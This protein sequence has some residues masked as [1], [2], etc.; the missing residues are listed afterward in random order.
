MD[1][2]NSNYNATYIVATALHPVLAL[3]LNESQLQSARQEIIELMKNE[4]AQDLTSEPSGG[5]IS[6][7]SGHHGCDIGD[8][9]PHLKQKIEAAKQ[10]GIKAVSSVEEEANAYF[11]QLAAFTNIKCEMEF[12]VS[13]QM[14]FPVLASLAFDVLAIPASSAAIESVFSIA[15][16]ATSAR[17]HNLSV[18][19]EK[20]VMIKVNKHFIW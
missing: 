9:F 16:H 14:Q 20:E 17:R 2:R 3:S 8:L 11:K 15:G 5:G 1:P 12:W 13:R 10:R 6:G 4:P 18:N 7:M 19:L